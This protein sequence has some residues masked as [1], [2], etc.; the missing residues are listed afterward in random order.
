MAEMISQ[1]KLR[2]IMDPRNKDEKLKMRFAR[3]FRDRKVDVEKE[4][5][6]PR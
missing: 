2:E 6:R 3:D 1:Q 5:R 4:K